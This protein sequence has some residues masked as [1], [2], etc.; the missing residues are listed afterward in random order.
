MRPGPDTD[1]PLLVD[2]HPPE[3]RNASWQTTK[4][5]SL[6]DYHTKMPGHSLHTPARVQT[7]QRLAHL[8]AVGDR[9]DLGHVSG[10]GRVAPMHQPAREGGD[11]L[12]LTQRLRVA[13]A[14][15]NQARIVRERSGGRIVGTER[16]A[17]AHRHA[18]LILQRRHGDLVAVP[19]AA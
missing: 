6:A 9:G 12:A 7:R 5:R 2:W 3:R 4:A 14:V 1:G 17:L 8:R 11:V 19:A 13:R 15:G 10:I 16:V 18:V